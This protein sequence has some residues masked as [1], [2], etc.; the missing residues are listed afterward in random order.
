SVSRLRLVH[1]VLFVA[2]A[3]RLVPPEPRSRPSSEGDLR[4]EEPGPAMVGSRYFPPAGMPAFASPY[5]IA[6]L[7]HPPPRSGRSRLASAVPAPSF[8][9]FYRREGRDRRG[10]WRQG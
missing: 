6:A 4:A 9:A 5:K 1:G 10:H 2:V 8:G 7:H 3:F